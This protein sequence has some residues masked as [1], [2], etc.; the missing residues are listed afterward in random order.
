VTCECPFAHCPNHH[1]PCGASGIYA[2][3][4]ASRLNLCRQCLGFLAG[5]TR[6]AKIAEGPAQPKCNTS[7]VVG[8]R[9]G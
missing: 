8:F 2:I 4:K 1:G 5:E 6:A 7:V 3:G 9:L